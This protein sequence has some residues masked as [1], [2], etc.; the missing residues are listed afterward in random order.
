M[1]RGASVINGILRRRL[2]DYPDSRHS[3]N[4]AGKTAY[5]WP[6]RDKFQNMGLILPT[7]ACCQFIPKESSSSSISAIILRILVLITIGLRYTCQGVGVFPQSGE[8]HRIEIVKGRL[9][10]GLERIIRSR[11]CKPIGLC[12]ACNHCRAPRIRIMA[13]LL[14]AKT[15]ARMIV[16]SRLEAHRPFDLAAPNI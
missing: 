3:K 12:V 6:R 15:C 16:T 14:C 8:W 1:S 11:V 13:A 10:L 7:N 2:Y 9:G 4:K 5:P